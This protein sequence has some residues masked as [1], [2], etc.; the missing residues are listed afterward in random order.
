MDTGRKNTKLFDIKREEG[1]EI[2]LDS[3]EASV[4]KRYKRLILK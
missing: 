1:I 4:K 3:S 2:W